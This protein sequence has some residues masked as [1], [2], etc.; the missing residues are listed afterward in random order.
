MTARRRR[1]LVV[2]TVSALAVLAVLLSLGTWQLER[3]AWKHGLIAML[4]ERLAAEPVTLPPPQEWSRLDAAAAEFRR[5]VFSAEFL[6]DREALVYTSGS[7]LRPDV[8]GPGYWV[9]TPARLPGG[10]IVMV[11]RGFVPEEQRTPAERGDG[12]VAGSTQI[13]GVLRWPEQPGLFTPDADPG[14]N[15]WYARDPA[16][17][18]AAKGIGPAAPFYVDQE[19]PSPPGGWPRPGKL[20]PRLPDNHLGYAVTWYGLALMLLAVYGAWVAGR[21][22]GTA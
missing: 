1:G 17:I 21:W 2:P 12:Q 3:R 10:A 16:A 6:N 14:R 22:R 13:V 4:R 5:I 8:S 15:V 18:A 9:F 19:F 20:Q 11:D 7:S